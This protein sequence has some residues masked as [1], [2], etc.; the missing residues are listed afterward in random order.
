MSDPSQRML[1][2]PYTQGYS[3]ILKQWCKFSIDRLSDTRWDR[4]ALDSVI[5]D[6]HRKDV[7]KALVLAH[8]F[9]QGP[10]DLITQ[11][12]KGLVVLL[13]GSPGSGKTMTAGKQGGLIDSVDNYF[14]VY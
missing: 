7:L 12:G 14:Q 2:P 13:Y 11:K 3:L 1:C 8:K 4:S 9:P 10:V 5:L 6:D